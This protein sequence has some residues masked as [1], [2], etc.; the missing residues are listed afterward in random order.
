MADIA[1]KVSFRGPD[2]CGIRIFD[3]GM[4]PGGEGNTALFFNRLAIMDLDHRS[5]QPFGDERYTLIFNGE[6][7]NY[8]ELKAILEGEGCS[9]QTTSDTEVLF[10]ALRR[11]GRSALPRINGM[12]AFCWLDRED[13][14]FLVARD[15]IGI[16]PVV[17]RQEGKHFIFASETDSVLRLSASL[18]EIDP[19]AI[20]MYLWMQFIPSPRTI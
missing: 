18:P 12:F 20:D 19:E 13:K 1:A 3:R 17:Y 6:I 16:K 14:S 10:F 7:Y 5:D 15:R 4:K 8:K 2:S 9:F 11:W